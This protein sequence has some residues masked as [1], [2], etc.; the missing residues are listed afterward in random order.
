VCRV[1]STVDGRPISTIVYTGEVRLSHLVGKQSNEIV[2]NDDGF[3]PTPSTFDASSGYFCR[4][5]SMMLFHAPL[6]SEFGTYKTVKA[7]FFPWFLG[8]SIYKL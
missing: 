1:R 6:S 7:G 8:F 2:S 5:I 3:E 4:L